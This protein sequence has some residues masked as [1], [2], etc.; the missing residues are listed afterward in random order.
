MNP[1]VRWSL[2]AALLLLFGLQ[3]TAPAQE[4]VTPP[5]RT[6]TVTG[7]GSVKVVADTVRL[8]FTLQAVG[9]T[10]KLGHDALQTNTRKFREALDGLKIASLTVQGGP[11]EVQMLTSPLGIGGTKGGK[12]KGGKGGL[13]G[14]N[15]QPGGFGGPNQPMAGP[16]PN[17]YLI[18]SFSLTLV[19]VTPGNRLIPT[20]LDQMNRIVL[21][22]AESGAT[23]DVEGTR[24][25]L[26]GRPVFSHSREN[27]FRK[28]ALD[29]ALADALAN[30]ERVAGGAKVRILRTATIMQM[31]PKEAPMT[32][33]EFDPIT[34]EKEIVI[35][36]SVTCEY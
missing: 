27:D 23:V 16:R 3:P 13:G 28:K 34:G 18:Q 4:G 35:H 24:R 33:N 22:A 14:W 20:L 36:I 31:A 7:V 11:L 5:K 17:Y 2:P 1:L 25:E 8:T 12:G 32:C 9:D 10:A 6:I 19:Q 15:A 26:T 29:L 21:V 30:A